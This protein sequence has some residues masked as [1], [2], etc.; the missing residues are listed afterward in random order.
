M[1]FIQLVHTLVPYVRRIT[2]YITY[3]ASYLDEHKFGFAENGT[4]IAQL[5]NVGI[6]MCE[7]CSLNRLGP[8]CSVYTHYAVT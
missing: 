5:L 6:G 8:I 7:K 3:T 4:E 2:T 1:V